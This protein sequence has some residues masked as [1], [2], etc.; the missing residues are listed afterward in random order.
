MEDP[1]SYHIYNE[2]AQSI[3]HQRQAPEN[4]LLFWKEA[5][6]MAGEELFTSEKTHNPAVLV[7]AATS[8]WQLIPDYP[9]IHRF[10]ETASTGQ[11][12]FVAVLVSFYNGEDGDALCREL[13]F[14]GVGDIAN[15]LEP[16]QLDIIMNL[17][18][19]HT[20]W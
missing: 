15:R 17:M 12:L 1:Q 13:G 4:F 11:A 2:I 10:M 5:V 18:K 9:A 7:G 3:E 16:R 6:K 14:H 19:Y 20:G 8:K